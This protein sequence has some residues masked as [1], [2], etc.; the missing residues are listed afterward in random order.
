MKSAPAKENGLRARKR[1]ET[2]QRIAEAGL[3]LF[4]RK[5]YEATTLEAI[6]AAA[7]ISART[8]FY[9]FKTKDEVLQFWQGSGFVEALGPAMRKASTRQA[10]LD[11]VRR[12][13]LKLVSRYETKNS[14]VVDRILQST[15]ALRTRKHAKSIEMEETLFAALCE[16]WPQPEQRPSLR[17]TAMISIGAMRLAME[18]WRRDNGTRS[19]AKY[20]RDSF[21]VLQA[22]L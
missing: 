17:M 21:A 18:A 10:P 7:G 16:L 19:L 11:A 15:E 12:C 20:L 6:A 2:R 13:L 9:Y 14:V 22:Q 8:F 3:K 1:R 4:V 5:G